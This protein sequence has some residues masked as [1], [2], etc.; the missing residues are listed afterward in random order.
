MEHHDSSSPWE[1]RRH[2]H[3]SRPAFRLPRP[4]RRPTR[5]SPI[6]SPPSPFSQN[7]QNEP[8]VAIDAHAPDVVV[9]GV[10]RRDRRGVLRC[11]RPDDCPSPRASACSGVY[12]SFNG[13]GALDPADLHGLDARATASGRP[14]AR[15]TSARSAR[16]PHY[17]EAGLVSD[18]DPAVAFGPRPGA[19]GHFSWSNGSRLYYANLTSNF[20]RPRRAGDVQGLRGDRGLARRR[21]RGRG[22]RHAAR[23]GR[24]RRSSRSSRR[25]RSPTRSRSGPTTRR[26]SRFF[27]NVYVCWASF[28]SN[29]RGNALPTPLT[30]SRSTRRRRRPGRPGRSVRPRTTASTPSPTAARCGPT[31]R[32]TS[33][34]SGSATRSGARATR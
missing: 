10:Q 7:K 15:R 24:R 30:V 9:A 18:G 26:R 31:A 34:S 29:S 25:P 6:G 28:R 4:W 12:F 2:W 22:R 14:R 23:P 16:C 33:T 27:G 11:R 1:P 3:C 5:W 32:A 21:R 13:G 20:A 17:Y 19:D 8:A